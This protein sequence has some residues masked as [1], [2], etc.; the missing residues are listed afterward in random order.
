MVIKNVRASANGYISRIKDFSPNARMFLIYV[1]LISLNLGVYKV[2]FN[3][4]ILR[5]GYT[6]DFLGL[7]LSLTSIATGIFSI[8]SAMICDMIGRKRTL[9]LSCLLLIVSLIFLYNTRLK[10]LL[11]FFSILYGASSALNIVTGSTF[12]LENSKPFERMHLFSMYQVLYTAATM[13]GNI[14]GG[15]FPAMMTKITTLDAS[16]FLAYRITLLLSLMTILVSFLPLLKIKERETAV[17]KHKGSYVFRTLL[18]SELV[19]MMILV[20]SFYGMGWGLALP[21]F[22]VYLDA[23]IGADSDEIGVIF[24]LG[25]VFMMIALLF[26]P[27]LTERFGKIRVASIVQLLSIPFLAMFISTSW[28]WIAGFAY[29]MRSALMNLANPVLN[30]FKLEIVTEEQR[31][32]MNSITWMT[33]YVF[34]GIGTFI[35][36]NVLAGG[37]Y[38]LPFILTCAM[39]AAAAILYYVRFDKVEKQQMNADVL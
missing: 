36:G 37:N 29:I 8:P 12:M 24:S 15:V 7:I 4:Y 16:G 11:V 10:E 38:R 21:Y 33:C 18:R 39:Y 2:I 34:V 25:E 26:L 22:N 14:V 35:G 20:Y 1:F 27:E 5:L 31:A 3:L 17:L 28:L 19:L 32:S 23:I 6:E 13:A 30:N 9:L